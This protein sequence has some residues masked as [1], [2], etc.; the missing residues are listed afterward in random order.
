MPGPLGPASCPCGWTV[1]WWV[2][3]GREAGLE[4]QT[5]EA[6][7][8]SGEDSGDSTEQVHPRTLRACLQRGTWQP[9]PPRTFGFQKPTAAWT[10]VVPSHSAPAGPEPW[11][12]RAVSQSWWWVGVCSEPAFRLDDAGS[13]SLGAPLSSTGRLPD[14]GPSR[15]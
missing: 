14:P 7:K 11:G 13:E 1:K 5:K 3:R 8:G 10:Q 2:H 15:P 12:L 6:E 9:P 4:S